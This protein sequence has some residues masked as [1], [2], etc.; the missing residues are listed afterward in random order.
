MRCMST[1]LSVTLQTDEEELLSAFAAE[2]SP[3]RQ[4]LVDWATEHRLAESSLRSDA[5]LLRLL[6][7]AGA[8]AL[9]ARAM[10]VGYS[11]LAL[12]YTPDEIE[13]RHAARNRYSARTEAV[14][15]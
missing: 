2:G 10:D 3:E 8:E 5:S 15:D 1:R 14:S 7:R 9:R 12:S 4:A 13:E 11:A 6:L